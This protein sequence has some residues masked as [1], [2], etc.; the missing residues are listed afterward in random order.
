VLGGLV[1]LSVAVAM[2]KSYAANSLGKGGE[3]SLQRDELALEK[4]KF[5][6]EESKLSAPS[7]AANVLKEG[8][9]NKAL[10]AVTA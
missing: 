9:L 1:L 8:V 7:P 4:K 6:L 2:L 3:K 10:D 5:A